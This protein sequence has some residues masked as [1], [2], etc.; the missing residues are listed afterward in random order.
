[1]S[2][3]NSTYGLD[4]TFGPGITTFHSLKKNTKQISPVMRDFSVSHKIY[5]NL[6]KTTWRA[7]S[8]IAYRFFLNKISFAFFFR[9]NQ[10]C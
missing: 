7:K 9:F 8:V 1:M 2:N 5:E 3:Y 10:D 6:A 4:L